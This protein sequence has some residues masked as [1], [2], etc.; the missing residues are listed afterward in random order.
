MQAEIAKMQTEIGKWRSPPI[1]VAEL[2]NVRV[3]WKGNAISRLCGPEQKCRLVPPKGKI[4]MHP[5]SATR[6][7]LGATVLLVRDVLA[8][9]NQHGRSEYNKFQGSALD[10][11]AK[12]TFAVESALRVGPPTVWPNR[13]KEGIPRYRKPP[14]LIRC[15]TIA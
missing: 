2:K 14:H 11:P 5:G 1:F 3:V 4:D 15:G 8:F 7:D 10:S 13:D 9:R 12:T 6:R